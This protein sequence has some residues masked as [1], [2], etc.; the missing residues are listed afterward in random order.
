MC[1]HGHEANPAPRPTAQSVA[2]TG[3]QS[4]KLRSAAVCLEF[5]AFFLLLLPWHDVGTYDVHTK[6]GGPNGSI[7]NEHELGHGAN[8]G[9]KIAINL[10]EEVKSKHPKITYADLYQLAG[11]LPLR[12][13]EVQ[14]LTLFQE[15]MIL[16]NLLKKDVFQMLNKLLA[17]F[18]SAL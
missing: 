4:T 14:L 5:L 2:I 16:W 17:K 3:H 8:S 1:D 9:L 11:L 7:R 13:L 18:C 12:S 6:T 15:E 10:C